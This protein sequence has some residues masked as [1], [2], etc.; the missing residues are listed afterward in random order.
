MNT[1]RSTP[2]LDPEDLAAFIDRRL[3]K[4]DRRRVEDHLVQCPDCYEVFVE[5]VRCLEDEAVAEDSEGDGASVHHGPWPGGRLLRFALPI[6]A[7]LVLGLCLWAALRAG[8]LGGAPGF[9]TP[10]EL[11]AGLDATALPA[12]AAASLVGDRGWPKSRGGSSRPDLP[13]IADVPPH[14]AFRLGTLTTDLA[15]VLDRSDLAPGE[16]RQ[17]LTKIETTLGQVD[18]GDALSNGYRDLA[19]R[20]AAGGER[21]AL[22]R[23][24]EAMAALTE[25]QVGAVPFR[26]GAWAEAGRLAAASKTGAP[27]RKGAFRRASKRLDREALPNSIDRAVERAL[28]SKA[29]A[30]AAEAFDDLVSLGGRRWPGMPEGPGGSSGVGGPRGTVPRDQG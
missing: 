26:L 19:A 29:P 16:V 22:R 30:Q 24:A 3:P 10:G 27:L 8:W 13:L 9:P 17:L 20:L 25:K 15:L 11:V 23:V 5:T 28:E 6:A 12:E 7:T 18:M 1:D 14:V 21:A 2:C 4:A